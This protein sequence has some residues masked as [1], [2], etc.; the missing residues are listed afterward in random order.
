MGLFM[1]YSSAYSYTHL[2]I[3]GLFYLCAFTLSASEQN[4]ADKNNQQ[5]VI[6]VTA[7]SVESLTFYPS[8]NAPAK[9]ESLN[10]SKIPAQIGAVVNRILVKVGDKIKRDDKLAKLDCRE[11]KLDLAAQNAKQKQLQENFEFKQRQVKRG[12]NLAKQKNIGDAELDQLKTNLVLAHSQ[13]L[14]QNALRDSARLNIQRCTITAPFNGMVTRRL[15]N[16]G[17]MINKGEPV[18]EMVQLDNLEVSASV[19]LADSLSFEQ[20]GSFYFETAEK[21]YPLVNRILLPLVINNTR[22]R[23][24]RL[25]FAS[26]SAMPGVTGR[27]FW[28]SSQAHIPAHLLQERNGH[29]GVFVVENKRAKF[30]EITQAQEG[31]PI[32]LNHYSQ[33]QGRQLVVD[34]RH[35]LLDGQQVFVSVSDKNKSISDKNQSIADKNRPIGSAKKEGAEH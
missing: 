28:L 19:S 14:A 5:R 25:N 27:L 33:W 6:G 7:A 22:S 34:G 21:Q 18:L 16:E 12:Q 35:G 11:V 30:I 32:P 24:A 17:E 23:E 9:T 26:K 15:A 13:L 31:R 1:R 10:Q 20:A 4:L 2:V 29:Y 8:R 3:F